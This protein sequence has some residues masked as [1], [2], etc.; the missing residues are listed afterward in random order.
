MWIAFT[1]LSLAKPGCIDTPLILTSALSAEK[2]SYSKSPILPPS[3]VYAVSTSRSV[4][5]CFFTPRPISSSGV[6]ATLMGP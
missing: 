1:N 5:N 6:N 2:V 4:A 3:K